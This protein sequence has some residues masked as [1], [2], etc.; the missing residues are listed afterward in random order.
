MRRNFAFLALIFAGASVGVTTA[1]PKESVRAEL[2]RK[3]AQ[4]GL[5]I[6]WYEA[7]GPEIVKFKKREVDRNNS[8]AKEFAGSGTISPDGTEIAFQLL[9]GNAVLGIMKADNSDLR[10]FPNVV[11]PGQ[12]CWSHDMSQIAMATAINETSVSLKVLDLESKSVKVIAPIERITS[13]C[14]SPDDKKLVFESGGNVVIQDVRG[15]AMPQTLAAGAGP[16][17]SPDGDWIAYLDER[18]HNYYVIH[19]NRRDKKKLFH[20]REGLAGLYWSPDGRIVA[21]VIEQGG[22]LLL[23]AEN[24]R[25]KVRRIEDN[26][27]DWV[28]DGVDCCANIQWVTNKALMARIEASPQPK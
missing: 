18:E 12:F 26:S 25:L 6:V 27:E 13:Q 4:D 11:R 28:A 2:T 8:L 5:T 16:T 10:E 19:P 1:Q 20:S 9:K 17:W 23:D 24:N 14:W 21:Y 3:Q 7:H 22:L 15:E